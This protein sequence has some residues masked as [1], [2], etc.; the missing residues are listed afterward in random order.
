MRIEVAF[1][2]ESGV[3]FAGGS[4]GVLEEGGAFT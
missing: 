2:G 1:A 3:A 4:L